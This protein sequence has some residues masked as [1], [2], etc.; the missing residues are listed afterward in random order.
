MVKDLKGG[1][2]DVLQGTNMHYPGEDKENN[3][4]L[5]GTA[6]WDLNWH[7]INKA[8]N[9]N[10]LG[11]DMVDK[12]KMCIRENKWRWVSMELIGQESLPYT[13][14]VLYKFE[15]SARGNSV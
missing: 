15:Y 9:A 10:L 11:E 2:C 12:Y 1:N 14:L 4:K 7:C 6:G 3:E 5:V 13:G 8:Q